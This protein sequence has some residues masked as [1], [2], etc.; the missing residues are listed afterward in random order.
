MT[1]SGIEKSEEASDYTFIVDLIGPV[2]DAE[3]RRILAICC[4][5][6]LVPIAVISVRHYGF[7]VTC[8]GG[9]ILYARRKCR[10]WEYTIR[11]EMFPQ[12]WKYYADKEMKNRLCDPVVAC[13]K[14]AVKAS[15]RCG[16]VS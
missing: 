10:K 7:V 8:V 1:S 2:S 16:A 14:S 15:K 13:S 12:K 11:P 5:M 3:R 4:E 9:V 6:R